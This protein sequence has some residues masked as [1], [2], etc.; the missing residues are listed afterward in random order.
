MYVFPSLPFH[1]GPADD[2]PAVTDAVQLEYEGSNEATTCRA[3]APFTLI[4]VIEFP[5]KLAVPARALSGAISTRVFPP[6]IFGGPPIENASEA[7]YVDQ[8]PMGG[9]W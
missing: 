8:V 4:T 9:L 2:F 5:W 3:T 7:A 6:P 1:C